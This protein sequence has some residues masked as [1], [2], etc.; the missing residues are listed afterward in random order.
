MVKRQ[1]RPVGKACIHHPEDGRGNR[2]VF[3]DGRHIRGAVYV[4]TRRGLVRAFDIPPRLHKHRK[5]VITRTLRGLVEV[6]LHE[7][8]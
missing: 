2:D 6:V 8:A 7:G 1:Q 5:R 4:D 3:V